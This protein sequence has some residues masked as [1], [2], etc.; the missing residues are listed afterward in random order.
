MR[1]KAILAAVTVALAWPHAIIGQSAPAPEALP[2]GARWEAEVP[3][4][5]NGTLLLYSRGYSPNVGNPAAAPKPHR[6]AL[7]DA[8]YAI[9]GSDYGSG[10]WSVEEAVPAQRATIAAFAAKYGKPK[11]VI[12]WGSSMGGLVSTAL[13]EI[14]G[15]GIDGAAAM[16]ASIGGSLGMMNMALDGAYAFRLLV[17]TDARIRLVDV[18][19]DRVNGKRAQDALTAAVKTPEGRA[20]VALAGV[21]S[22]IPHWTS[23]DKPE[24]AATDY[25]AQADEIARAFVMGTYLP[26]TDQEKRAGGAFSWNTGVDYRA[27]LARSGRWAMVAA[28]YAKAG[29]KLDADLARLNA[30][31]R[32]AAKPS[33]VDYMRANYTPNARPLVPLVA[34]QT[35][36]DGMTPPALQRGYAEAARGRGVKSLYVNGAGHCTFDTATTLA[37]IRYLDQRIANGKWPATPAVF[38]AHMPAPMLRPCVRGGTCK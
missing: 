10:G 1:R 16:C 4:K 30:G 6:Q 11:R 14:K 31:K 23:R 19:D 8:G 17:A 24:P 20:R 38:V 33:A 18:D 25:D 5:W 27:Q 3:A 15:S 37:T 35:I 34:V 7:L 9:A 2:G 22:G 32:I 13:A 21:L 29:L 12:A 28:L 26:R 36:G